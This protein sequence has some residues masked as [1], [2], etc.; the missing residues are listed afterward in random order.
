[1]LPSV[2]EMTKCRPADTP[3]YPRHQRFDRTNT[4]HLIGLLAIW[5]FLFS[6]VYAVLT[7]KDHH[8]SK[9]KEFDRTYSR[10]H[11]ALDGM[12]FSVVTE[13]T[14]GGDLP[15]QGLSRLAESIEVL[16]GIVIAGLFVTRYTTGPSGKTKVII[17]RMSGGWIEFCKLSDQKIL[18]SL[19]HIR[20][21]KGLLRYDGINFDD[22][23]EEVRDPCYLGIFEGSSEP[24][25]SINGP[26]IWFDYS[27]LEGDKASFTSGRT[28][29]HFSLQPGHQREHLR[30]DWLRK[31]FRLS[32]QIDQSRERHTRPYDY[33]EGLA[34]DK[35]KGLVP[36]FACRLSEKDKEKL[37]TKRLYSD[38]MQSQRVALVRELLPKC[39]K[40]AAKFETI[41]KQHEDR[42]ERLRL[43]ER[44]K[45]VSGDSKPESIENRSSLDQSS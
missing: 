37:A 39:K 18:T 38:K 23:G 6:G 33:F 14:I 40:Q 29:L 42:M 25:S 21:E 34:D 45:S 9:S 3:T 19:I 15:P 44:R 12:Y 26:E 10:W 2:D 7:Y 1:M 24:M 13:T 4:W 30:F 32:N 27:N 20:F 16:G 31:K 36:I 22:P 8:E 43:A 35:E 17:S 5:T 11:A 41:L 28:S